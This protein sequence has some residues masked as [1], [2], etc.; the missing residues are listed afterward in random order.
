MDTQNKAFSLKN[1]H[2]RTSY[3]KYKKSVIE[4]K[5]HVQKLDHAMQREKVII[6]RLRNAYK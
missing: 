3:Y 2:H 4:M 5:E 1:A 6:E